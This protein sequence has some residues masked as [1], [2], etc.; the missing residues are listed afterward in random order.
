MVS[1]QECIP[2]LFPRG[3]QLLHRKI[4]TISFPEGGARR[5][6]SALLTG[7]CQANVCLPLG[8]QGSQQP[9][10]GLLACPL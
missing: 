8:P 3:E 10:L 9:A 6:A 4:H 2:L 5:G 1:F 7:L